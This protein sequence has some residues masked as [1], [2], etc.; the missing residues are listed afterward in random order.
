M[1]KQK[2]HSEQTG[3]ESE[4]A[5]WNNPPGEPAQFVKNHRGNVLLWPK[6]GDAKKSL[7]QCW[8]ILARW[9][10]VVPVETHFQ[11]QRVKCHSTK[12]KKGGK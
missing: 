2:M 3:H 10:Q 5:I 7:A 4:W 9:C 6:E 1:S 12:P 11:I 8:P